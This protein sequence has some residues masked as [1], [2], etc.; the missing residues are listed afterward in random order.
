MPEDRVTRKL[1][2]ILYAD[3]VGYSRLTGAD[4]EGTH[5]TVVAYLDAMAEMVS[6]H[7]GHVVHYAG[8]AVLAEFASVIAAVNCA[9]DVQKA[10]A[11]RVTKISDDRKVQFRIGVNLGDVIVDRDNIFGNGVNI[12]ARLEALAEPGGI[13]VSAS[14][15]EQ[16]KDTLDVGFEN[17]GPQKVKNIAEPVSAYRVRLDLPSN[18]DA[19]QPLPDKPSIAVLPFDNLSGDP[20]QDY[21]ADGIAEEIT[22]ALSRL[23]WFHTIARNSSF[24][25]KGQSVDVRQLGRELGARYVLEGSVRKAGGRVRITAQLID[26]V[27]RSHLWADRFDG[28]L[29]DI[30]EVQD[31]ISASVVGAIA[32]SVQD[33]EIVRARS[34]RSENLTAYDNYLRALPHYRAHTVDGFSEALK[35]LNKAR[36]LDADFP[37]ATALAAICMFRPIG[38]IWTDWSDAGVEEAVG[39]A[40]EALVGGKNDPLIMVYAASVLALGGREYET[41]VALV[42]NALRLAPYHAEVLERAG[43]IEIWSAELDAAIEHLQRARQ[44]NPK[45]PGMYDILNGLAA[46]HFF[47]AHYAAA[48]EWARKA[49][50]QKP[51]FAVALRYLAASLAHM[52]RLDEARVAKEQLLSIQPHCTV[53]MVERITARMAKDPSMIAPYLSGLRLAGLPE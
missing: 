30:F 33:A 3:V 39:L 38:G 45:D 29:E 43:W 41:S 48:A 22:T 21:F 31:Q 19:L 1:A 52:D 49:H 44:L 20:E 10:S 8:D 27:S 32:P 18:V 36:E 47:S 6:E 42:N 50:A 46:A 15:F 12:A 13:C 40:R 25:F 37:L 16:V 2:A 17:M 28:N 11:D 5:R 9:V 26:T 34:L 35:L 7:G 24:V 53:S 23:P 4:E 14:V 51:D